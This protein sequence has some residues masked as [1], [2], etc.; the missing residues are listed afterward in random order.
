MTKIGFLLLGLLLPIAL[1]TP[2]PAGGA[3]AEAQQAPRASWRHVHFH[4]N[5]YPEAG[6]GPHGAPLGCSGTWDDPHG[7]CYGRGESHHSYPFD[8]YVAWRWNQQPTRCPALAH[9]DHQVWTHELHLQSNV[10]GWGTSTLCGWV[11][12]HWG[13]LVVTGGHVYTNGGIHQI[14]PSSTV[15]ADRETR[16]GPLFVHLSHREGGYV[17]GLRGYL[18]Y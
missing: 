13:T 1:L 17:L 6:S 2:V 15:V 9:R 10:P 11:D 12:R 4:M 7:T 14:H 16:G 3:S 8:H 5:A 18:D